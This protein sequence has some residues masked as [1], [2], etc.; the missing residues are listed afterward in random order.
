MVRTIVKQPR[1]LELL[2]TIRASLLEIIALAPT[3]SKPAS[4]RTREMLDELRTD[5]DRAFSTL[6]PVKEPAVWFDP[7]DPNTAGRLVAAALL[8]QP[9]VP[10]ELVP[11]SYGAGVY[12]IY[13]NGDYPAYKPL[14]QTETPIYVGKADPVSGSSKTPRDQGQKLYGRLADHRKMIRTVAAYAVTEKIE[15]ALRL[16]DF[17]C[18]HLVTATNAQMFA[19]RHLIGLFKP[20]WNRETGVCW[21]ISKHG[22]TDGRNNDRSPWDVLHP[23]RKWAM[24]EKLEDSRPVERILAD[25]ALHFELNPSFQDRDEVIEK[26]LDAFAQNPM[27]AASPVLD[28]EIRLEDAASE[29]A[30]SG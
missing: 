5:I 4:K 9:R 30:L 25:I 13:Y 1:Q 21:G 3:L 12:A 15:P 29:E 18:R 2:E 20:L 16:E 17:E 28:D 19:E 6:D 8:A 22:D 27:T 26:F 23:G 24:A 11:R 14:S 10:L 7:S